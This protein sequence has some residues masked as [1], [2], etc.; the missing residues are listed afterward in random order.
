[1]DMFKI[2]FTG[3]PCAGK[4]TLIDKTKKYLLEKGYDVLV[5]PETATILKQIGLDF[6]SVG[7]VKEFQEA[8]FKAQKFYEDLVIQ[9][10]R[11]NKSKL[12]ILYDR[13]ILDNKAYCGSSEIFDSILKKHHS[14]ELEELDDYDVVLNLVSLAVCNPKKYNLTSNTQRTENIEEAAQ[15]DK[16]TSDV[17]AGHRNLKII[18]SNITIEE[19]FEI[20]KKSIINLINGIDIKDINQIYLD[21]TLEDFNDYNDNNSRLIKIQR[22][23]LNVEN[24]NNEY[25]LYKRSYK[26]NETYILQIYKYLGNSKIVY[27][28]KKIS[29][30]E[31]LGFI[32]RYKLKDIEIYKQL[33]FVK[34]RQLYEIKFLKNATILEYEEN[35]LNEKLVL[36]NNLKIVKEKTLL[37]KKK[38]DNIK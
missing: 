27:C 8:M 31:Y 32:T 36:P 9:T 38:D 19:S 4:T 15:I 25:V 6:E 21:N 33:S 24:T 16:K 1:M 29:F 37:K 2:V 7:S 30:Q 18:N 23:V 26:D 20:I 17:W 13:G 34:D 22:M 5:I 12:I 11:R 35:K 28:D 3:G 10:P 14:F